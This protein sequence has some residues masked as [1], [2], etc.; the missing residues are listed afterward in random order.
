MAL[1][2]PTTEDLAQQYLAQF[3]A[4]LNQNSPLNDKA[5]LIVLSALEAG[6]DQ[7]LF[8]YAAERALQN[9]A[10]TATG[11]DLDR[12]G[13]EYDTPRDQGQATVLTATI[14]GTDSTVI[15]V[16][17]EFVGDPNGVRYF[18]DAQATI[19]GGSATLSMTA[20]N[21]GALG[22]LNVTD[23]LTIGTQ[24]P[25]ADT[26]ATV[27]AVTTTGADKESD[28]SYRPRVLSAVRASCGGGNATDY[29]I[30]A[31]GVSGVFKAFPYGG[32]PTGTDYP[33]DRTVYIQAESSIDA[34]GIAPQSLL[35]DVRYAL[36]YDPATG[37]SRPPL[38]LIDATL[39]VESITRTS[40]YVEVR[41]LVVDPAVETKTKNEITTAVTA[42]LAN[43]T[44]YVAGID[45]ESE[46]NDRITDLTLSDVL[47]DV[48][49]A[50]S[51][52]ATG[53]GF[54]LAPSTFL[55]SYLLGEG[56]LVKLGGTIL[57][58]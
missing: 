29:K 17:T 34:D 49:T 25:G 32:R 50:N 10:T 41:G 16:N 44:P 22:N 18:T 45:V 38:G 43:I 11:E 2:L 58:V 47:Q 36:N 39:F 57:Y 13:E 54:G 30:W 9:L 20:E 55:A 1:N 15:P 53:V 7:G 6:G 8:K 46:R 37:E 27:T 40:I 28:E 14:T 51:A 21:I 3:E 12:I 23:T 31:E 5:F 52:S 42:Y 56:E 24:I 48:L 19:S 35:D 33:A 26:T 4:L